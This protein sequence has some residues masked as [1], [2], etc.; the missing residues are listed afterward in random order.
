MIPS[1]TLI[2]REMREYGIADRLP[3]IRRIQQREA[4]CRQLPL[5]RRERQG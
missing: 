3:A 2:A 5:L 1:E 4:L